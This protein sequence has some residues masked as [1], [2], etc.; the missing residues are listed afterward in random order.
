MFKIRGIL[1]W[2][3]QTF[4]NCSEIGIRM[5]QMFRTEVSFLS[6]WHIIYFCFKDFIIKMC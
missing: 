6:V 4:L 3:S 5:T 2:V 1:R